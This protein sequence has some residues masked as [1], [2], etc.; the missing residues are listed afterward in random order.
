[1]NFRWFE[2]LIQGRNFYVGRRLHHKILVAD[3]HYGLVGGVN[4]SN[5]Y[6]DLQGEPA[7]LDWAILVEGEISMAL[8]HR[9]TQMWYRITRVNI[10]AFPPPPLI[11]E[12]CLMRMRVNDWVRNKNQIS[13]SYIE[14]F[15]KA[16]RSITIMSSY[17]LPG[18]VFRRN[19]RLA[20]SRG[21][22]VRII[23]TK[24]SDVALAKWAERFFYPWLLKR[25][26]EVYEYR[27]KVLHAKL[28]TYDNKWVTIGSYNVNDL[29]AYA[30]IE[31]NLD[32]DNEI[33]A[34]HVE[35]SLN[36]IIERDCDV[37]TT[38][39][40]QRKENFISR[41]LYRLAFGTFRLGLYLFT[42]YFKQE[43]LP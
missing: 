40:L 17:C 13:K 12:D 33:F 31:L 1:V 20:V 27:R 10:P 36:E 39:S 14:M 18:R 34:T 4:I 19:L 41:L 3:G 22:R 37:I 35:Q 16:D 9:C 11:N 25:N 23:M 15:R 32:V 21:V 7:W 8:Y 6:N 30:S 42:F 43:R 26:I 29:S 2:P 5:H 28:A 24:V 38:A